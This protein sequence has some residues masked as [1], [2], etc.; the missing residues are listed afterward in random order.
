M[1]E[2]NSGINWKTKNKTKK[3]IQKCYWKNEDQNW[4]KNQIKL[5]VEG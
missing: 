1:K 5:N 4:I 2:N 3:M